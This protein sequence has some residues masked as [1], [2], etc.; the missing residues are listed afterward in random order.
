VTPRFGPIREL[1]SGHAS[2]EARGEERLPPGANM[3]GENGATLATER[4]S[5][6]EVSGARNKAADHFMVMWCPA[7]VEARNA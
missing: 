4:A 6:S 3:V 2:K 7:A 1:G 5:V